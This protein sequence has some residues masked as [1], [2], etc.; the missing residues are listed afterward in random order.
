MSIKV[1]EFIIQAKI[2][3][4]GDDP[5]VSNDE[6]EDEEL[7]SSIKQEIIDECIDK[8][9]ELLEREKARY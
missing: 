1:N 8:M 6:S 4:D 3:E 2:I 9:K 5:A 7:A